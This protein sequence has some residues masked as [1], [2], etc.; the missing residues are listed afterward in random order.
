M[1]AQ[2]LLPALFAGAVLLLLAPGATEPIA[3]ATEQASSANDQKDG[4]AT[5]E[6]LRE[7]V[8]LDNTAKPVAGASYHGD[9]SCRW[10]NDGECDDP[11]IGTGACQAGTDYSDCWRIAQGVEDDTCQWANDGECDEPHFGT[12][13]CTQATDHADCGD[14]GYLK[15]QTDTCATAFDG[16]CNEPG[17]GDGTCEARTDRSDCLGRERP[18]LIYDNYFGYDDRIL[19]DTNEMPWSVIGLLTLTADGAGCTATLVAINVVAT[20][21]HC[22]TTENGGIDARADFEI[23]IDGRTAVHSARVTAYLVADTTGQKITDKSETDWALLR[24]DRPLGSALGYLGIRALGE[25]PLEQVQNMIVYQAGYS[26]DTGDHLSGNIGCAI[27]QF[28]GNNMLQHNCDTTHGDSGSPLMIEDNG[29]YYVVATDAAFDTDENGQII[30]IATR[31]D[32]W[33]PLLADFAAGEI[34]TT[35]DLPTKAPMRK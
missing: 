28:A 12:G 34:G 13:A 15:F 6:R 9:D 4:L 3:A 29:L 16:V 30:N 11:R 8:H 5:L 35:V 22:I 33:A 27:L 21:A 25:V 18:P 23:G 20:A 24:L 1:R 10:A 14:V 31:V 2:T 17:T 26:W 19:V 32:A 7:M